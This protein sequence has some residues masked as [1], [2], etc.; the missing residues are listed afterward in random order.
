MDTALRPKDPAVLLIPGSAGA[1]RD[2]VVDLR[3][4][5]IPPHFVQPWA[6]VEIVQDSGICGGVGGRLEG[7]NGQPGGGGG[8]G[9]GAK[10]GGKP[11]ER[12][13][14]VE[15][16]G[17]GPIPFHTSPTHVLGTNHR[18]LQ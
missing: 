11:G 2:P 18:E 13:K 8:D 9:S 7:G 4:S 3:V 10:S 5:A 14:G 16:A 15:A 6:S 1:A 12:E 17:F